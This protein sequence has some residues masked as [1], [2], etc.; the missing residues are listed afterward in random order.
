MYRKAPGT[1]K[2]YLKGSGIYRNTHTHTHTLVWESAH[3]TGIPTQNSDTCP[4]DPCIGG[5]LIQ[6]VVKSKDFNRHWALIFTFLESHAWV[7][8]QKLQSHIWFH[9]NLTQQPD[10]TK[11]SHSMRQRIRTKNPMRHTHQVSQCSPIL[12]KSRVEEQLQSY[13]HCI[14]YGATSEVGFGSPS[15]FPFPMHMVFGVS[16]KKVGIHKA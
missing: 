13:W 9:N 2:A 4:M 5:R 3:P 8:N 15:P 11:T 12:L 14:F 16:Q 6:K 7:W 10:H 1:N